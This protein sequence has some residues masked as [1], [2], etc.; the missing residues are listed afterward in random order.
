MATSVPKNLSDKQNKNS[1]NIAGGIAGA[2]IGGIIA[3]LANN[4]ADNNPYK[5]W[6][7]I[8]SP[9]IA[10]VISWL[11]KQVDIYLKKKK[12]KRLKGSI[13]AEIDEMMKRPGLT[14]QMKEKLQKT[15]DELDMANIEVLATRIR[16]I[17]EEIT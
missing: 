7:V 4:L 16:S 2:G 17:T 3:S 12:L 8:L 9:A 5:S 10:I 15:K 1:N 13:K 6:L 14:P 11:I